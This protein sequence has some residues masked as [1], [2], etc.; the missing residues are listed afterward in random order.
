MT[1]HLDSTPQYLFSEVATRLGVNTATATAWRT[2]KHFRVDPQSDAPATKGLPHL[3]SERDGV[4]LSIMAALAAQGLPL[5]DAGAAASR[6]ADGPL[7][8]TPG[9]AFLLV[10]SGSRAEVVGSIDAAALTADQ[11]AFTVL[12]LA[13]RVALT[14]H[15][16][17]G[18]PKRLGAGSALHR[19]K[20]AV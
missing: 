2:A 20:E 19:Q 9:P 14:R 6:V 4:R 16:L 7:A 3:L 13:E 12:N 17:A 15:A 5:T 8:C 10:R 1:D 18:L 11:H